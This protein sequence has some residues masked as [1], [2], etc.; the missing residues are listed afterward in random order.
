ME[1]P[2]VSNSGHTFMLLVCVENLFAPMFYLFTLLYSCAAFLTELFYFFFRVC[3][4]VSFGIDCV[5][6]CIFSG[7]IFYCCHTP[8]RLFIFILLSFSQ[9]HRWYVFVLLASLLDTK[10]TIVP[11]IQTIQL[12]VNLLFAV[13]LQPLP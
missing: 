10:L 8:V 13:Q 11:H 4:V 6:H 1:R 12:F 2:K 3:R 7:F 9:G 5:L